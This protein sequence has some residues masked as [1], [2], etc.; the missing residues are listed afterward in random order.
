MAELPGH[1][2]FLCTLFQPELGG[3]EVRP[4]A[5]VRA[6]AA[7]AAAHATSRNGA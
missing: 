3:D 7:A 6:F 4:H 1:P 5:V 2:F